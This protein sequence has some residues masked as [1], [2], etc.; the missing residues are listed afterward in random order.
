MS[1]HA[2]NRFSL[3]AL[4]ALLMFP[5][6]GFAQQQTDSLDCD[7]CVQRLHAQCPIKKGEG[8]T[9]VSVAAVGDTVAVEIET[10]ASLNA[11]MATLTQNIVNTKRLWVRYVSY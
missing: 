10:P 9:V 2:M 1:H 4:L 6:L 5:V 3:F 7:T 8:W 11:Y